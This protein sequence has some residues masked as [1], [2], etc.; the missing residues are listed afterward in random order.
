MF[1]FVRC[2]IRKTGP[3]NEEYW[4][5]HPPGR[6]PLSNHSGAHRT[7]AAVGHAGHHRNEPE[8]GTEAGSGVQEED[9]QP[10]RSALGVAFMAGEEEGRAEGVHVVDDSSE[11]RRVGGDCV[12]LNM[13]DTRCNNGC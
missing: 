3:N 9:A 10:L 13:R 1:T 4:T 12:S 6:V 7:R 8:A 11:H 2:Y 5:C